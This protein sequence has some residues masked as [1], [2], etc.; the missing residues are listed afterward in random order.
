MDCIG[1]ESRKKDEINIARDE[2]NKNQVNAI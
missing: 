1:I 2:I